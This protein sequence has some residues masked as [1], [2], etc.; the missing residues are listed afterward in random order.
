MACASDTPVQP[1]PCGLRPK[2]KETEVLAEQ[3]EGCHSFYCYVT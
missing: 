2:E 1:S 3:P